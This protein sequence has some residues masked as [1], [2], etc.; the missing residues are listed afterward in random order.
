MNKKTEEVP[1]LKKRQI[2]IETNGDD[3]TLVKAEVTGR[4]ELMGILQALFAQLNNPQ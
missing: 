2:I 1:V 3:V 4:I